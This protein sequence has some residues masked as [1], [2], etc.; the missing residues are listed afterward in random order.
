MQFWRFQCQVNKCE[1]TD[2]YCH[3]FCI[4]S[5]VLCLRGPPR[6]ARHQTDI[7]YITNVH[8]STCIVTLCKY[9]CICIQETIDAIR[10]GWGTTDQFMTPR[11]LQCKAI[12]YTERLSQ[13]YW[14]VPQA[15]TKVLYSMYLAWHQ[16]L[17]WWTSITWS[18]QGNTQHCC[19]H[20]ACWIY[21][22]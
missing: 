14:P 16:N 9:T 7:V 10:S 3:I 4:Y 6:A 22:I 11:I 2:S 19:E 20:G 12:S 8:I 13:L 21:H 15:R 17:Y 18:G 1:G 5:T